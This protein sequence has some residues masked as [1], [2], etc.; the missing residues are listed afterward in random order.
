MDW[1]SS[2]TG[3]SIYWYIHRSN[4]SIT[5]CIFRQ[6][7]LPF[8]LFCNLFMEG[9][10]TKRLMTL[11]SLATALL[12]ILPIT[13][14]QAETYRWIDDS[15][16]VNFSDDLGKIPV[17]YR[18][19]ATIDNVNSNLNIMPGR[20]PAESVKGNSKAAESPLTNLSSGS[21]AKKV[22]KSKHH[23][24]EKKKQRRAFSNAPGEA[25]T[26]RQQ[27]NLNEEKIRQDRQKLDGAQNPARQS[28][29]QADEQIKKAREK[30]MGH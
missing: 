7:S 9:A 28:I 13:N 23:T 26:A 27:Q 22:K 18:Q 1:T 6:H 4:R 8:S 29:N 11:R 16:G 3:K 19:N 21:A 17:R 12:F 20:A 14:I 24:P 30:T 10:M 5:R 25:N 15:G 2:K